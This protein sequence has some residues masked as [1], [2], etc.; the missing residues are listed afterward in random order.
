MSYHHP[1][2]PKLDMARADQMFPVLSGPLIARVREH[3]RVRRVERGELLV[4][5][6]DQQVPFFV[7]ISG[8]V[9]IKLTAETSE[10]PFFVYKAGNFTGEISVLTG[11]RALAQI[12]VIE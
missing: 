2:I 5:I 4:E 10:K 8:E 11:R 1:P 7:V 3:G 6:G 12:R 9:G